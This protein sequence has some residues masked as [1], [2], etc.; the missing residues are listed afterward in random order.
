M[1]N[2]QTLTVCYGLPG[3]GKSTWASEQADTND[4]TIRVNR[5][6]IRTMFYSNYGVYWTKPQLEDLVTAIERTAVRTALSQGLN[7]IVD[8]TNFGKSFKNWTKLAFDVS[9]S[10]GR[11]IG[12]QMKRF[13]TPIEVCIERDSKRPYPVGADI[14]R[15][16]H[17]RFYR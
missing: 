7:V 3:S 15:S 12:V 14:I 5:D 11:G 17:E 2:C 8:A 13:D 4:N 10:T 16:M 1:T 9:Q 6:S